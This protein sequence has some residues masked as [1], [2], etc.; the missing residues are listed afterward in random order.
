MLRACGA[1]YENGFL[2]HMFI[3]EILA[4]ASRDVS[5]SKLILTK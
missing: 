4:I 2:D 3:T 5:R 1:T